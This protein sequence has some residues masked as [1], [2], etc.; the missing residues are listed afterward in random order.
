MTVDP[1]W[2]VWLSVALSVIGFLTGAGAQ[3]TDLGLSAT[4]VKAILA[5]STLLLGVGNAVNA[6]LAAIPSKSDPET[7]K[8]FYLGPKTP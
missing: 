8:K 4:Q 7:L 2:S 3:F 5:L 6:V 1:R